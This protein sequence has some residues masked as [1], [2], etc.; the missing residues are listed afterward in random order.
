M[1]ILNNI[2]VIL[3]SPLLKNIVQN[4]MTNNASSRDGDDDDDKSEE[5]YTTSSM[6]EALKVAET[7]NGFVQTNCDNDDV[8]KST[9][10]YS[11]YC[12]KYLLSN[13]KWPII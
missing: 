7:L 8:L 2:C 1:R 4:I 3:V 6:S 11:Q 12:S 13:K 5:S 10:S 9:T